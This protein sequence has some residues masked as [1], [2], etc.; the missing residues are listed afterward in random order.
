M[1]RN[2]DPV[3]R[4]RRYDSTRRQERARQTRDAILD[5]AR[6]RFLDDGFTATTIA[7]IAS[8]AEVSVDT[9]Y[10]TFGGK[11]GLVSAICEKGLAGEGP[12]HAEDRSDALQ[13]R[14]PDPRKIMRGIGKLAAEVAPRVAPIMLLV[15]DA[16]VSDPEM[17]ALKAELDDQRLERMTQNAR[18]L[19]DAGHL[20]A[21]LAVETAG[22]IMWTYS[23]PELYELLV[24]RRGWQIERLGQFI[25]NALTAALLPSK[26][27]PRRTTRH[28]A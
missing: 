3:K 25:A 23:S 28:R 9:I 5:V 8:E 16:A 18:R 20:R 6:R 4:R 26:A 7:A 19:A 27:P 24:I 11:P 14:E 22:E 17:A 10:K 12:E 2:M 21:G 1:E 15:R 13:T